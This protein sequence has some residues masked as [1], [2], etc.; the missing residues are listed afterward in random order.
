[1]DWQALLNVAVV[2]ILFLVIMRGCVG[3]RR[4]CG[5]RDGG[6]RRDSG[7]GCAPGERHRNVDVQKDDES[8]RRP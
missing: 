3:M 2:V 6:T 8:T 1:M 4:G 5:A 7:A